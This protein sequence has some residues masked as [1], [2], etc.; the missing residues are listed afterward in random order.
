MIDFLIGKFVKNPQDINSDK[1]RKSYGN[2]SSGVGFVVNLL[3]FTFKLIVGLLSNSI[4]IIADAINNLSD[5]FSIG[6]MLI[7]FK[8]SAKPADEKHPYGHARIEYLFSSVITIIVIIVGVELMITSVKKIINPEQ[9]TFDISSIIV[10]VVA[11][12]LKIWLSR[13]YT[14]ISGIIHS[15]L[16]QATAVD[17]KADSIST[18][19]VLI[20]VLV[21]A[22]LDINVDAYVGL[23]GAIIII[24]S[25]FEMIMSTIDKLLGQKVSKEVEDSIY[26]IIDDNKYVQGGHDLTVHD[27]G[28][29]HMFCS[30]DVEIDSDMDLLTAH[31]VVDSIEREIKDKLYID[32]TI[33]M[34]PIL[35]EDSKDPIQKIKL[36]VSSIDD[37]W[38][39]HDIRIDQGKEKTKVII[40]L[41]I[42]YDEEMTN[43]EIYDKV[44]KKLSEIDPSYMALITL[45]KGY[46][47]E[48]LK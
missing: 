12:I 21:Y 28:P 18:S 6:I 3:L 44:D 1:T 36:A 39:V 20:S 13:F 31:N 45:R 35:K 17:S 43:E 9:I 37:D 22:F 25:G 16:L 2:L 14:H 41:S 32:A 24:K 11:I 7:S 34:D 4:A 8:L 15:D 19:I 46:Q 26:K 42:G 10:L 5:V 30:V 48:I 29:G 23:L 47:R 27:Y 38:E 40:D 33:H